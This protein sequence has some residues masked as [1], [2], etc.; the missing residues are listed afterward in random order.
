MTD[1]PDQSVAWLSRLPGFA[2][3]LFFGFLS[4]YVSNWA[5]EKFRPK[6]KDTHVK[7]EL[8]EGSAN[9]SGIMTHEN[10]EQVLDLMKAAA[11]ERSEPKSKSSTYD[12]SSA[13]GKTGVSSGETVKIAD[14][15]AITLMDKN[16]NITETRE[17]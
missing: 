8:T 12:A 14:S 17:I 5:W 3:G 4:G 9:F 10:S 6:R 15:I 7:I 11:A 16:G 1:Q 2:T 13:Q